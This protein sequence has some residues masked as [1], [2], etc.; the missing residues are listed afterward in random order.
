[1]PLFLIFIIFNNHS[2][3]TIIHSFILHHWP[4]PIFLYP[5]RFF[6]QQEKNLHEVPSRESNSGLPYSKPTRYQLSLAAPYWATPHLAEPRR[7]LLSHAAPCWILLT[8]SLYVQYYM[9]TLFERFEKIH[10]WL[11]HLYVDVRE[12]KETHLNI[13]RWFFF[14]FDKIRLS[15]LIFFLLPAQHPS[16]SQP[17]WSEKRDRQ[18]QVI[19]LRISDTV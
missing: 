14:F 1:M 19:N 16:V 2:H 10:I 17:S 6:A 4:R 12:R 11:Q 7:T 9:R 18:F 13:L 8:C 15:K 3:S 5:H